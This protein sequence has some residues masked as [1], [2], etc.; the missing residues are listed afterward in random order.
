MLLAQFILVDSH[1]VLSLLAALVF[2]AIAWLYFDAWV[3]NRKMKETTLFFGFLF[4]AVSFVAEAVIIDQA[5]LSSSILG[6]G[7]AALI[8]N[9]FRIAGYVTLIIG[10]ISVP[11]QPVPDIGKKTVNAIFP[12]SLLTNGFS[13]VAIFALPILAVTTGFLH[14]KRA[15]I[16]LENHLKPI[17]LGFFL[18][19]ISEA[20]GLS[21]IFRDTNNFLFSEFVGPFGILWIAERVF[22]LFAVLTFGK[23]V[24][25]YLLKRFDTQLFMIF[26]TLSLVIFLVTT[27]FFTYATLRNL[28]NEAYDS[29]KV[30]TGVLSYA[31]EAKKAELTSSAELT[32]Q[33]PDLAGAIES[34][35][36]GSISGLTSGTLLAKK[37]S[38]LVVVGANGEILFKAEDPDFSGGSLSDNSLVKRAIG[39]VA[40]SGVSTKDGV[41][42][43]VGVVSAAVPVTG[44]SG[45]V[46]AVLVSF[47]IDNAFADGVKAA[48]SL[49]TSIYAENIR[50]ATTFVTPDGSRYIGIKEESPVIKKT[51]LVD[52]LSYT[53][54]VN[55]LNVPFFANYS[56]L[57]DTDGNPV[58]M[59]FTGRQQISVLQTAARSLELTF[60][61]TVVLLVLS[62]IPS[63]FVSKHISDQIR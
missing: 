17:S 14:L 11:L 63:Y 34:S 31:I 48:T 18:L 8:K 26:T 60:L 7:T 47:D 32:A 41:T 30:D 55:V 36:K 20:F 9:L 58:G 33:N 61:V 56:P 10:Q 45:V 51:V 21:V 49:D 4:L 52:G 12:V 24:W 28:T 59:L 43:P 15:T 46:G 57:T 5:L 13:L 39:G 22:L 35:S 44:A 29:L 40:A 16:G 62:I 23:W 54:S 2:F 38:S 1:F 53:G 6:S 50:S 27:V 42:A 37:I 25:G 19:S 3:A